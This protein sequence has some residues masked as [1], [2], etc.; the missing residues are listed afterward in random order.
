MPT[1]TAQ[2][3]I[4]QLRGAIADAARGDRMLPNAI[5]TALKIEQLTFSQVRRSTRALTIS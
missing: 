3:M 2:A 1:G 5:E 4:R